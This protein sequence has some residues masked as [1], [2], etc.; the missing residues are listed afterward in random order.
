MYRAGWLWALFPYVEPDRQLNSAEETVSK[1]EDER[2]G[3]SR[4]EVWSLFDPRN[5]Q[6]LLIGIWYAVWFGMAILGVFWLREALSSRVWLMPILL[7]LTLTAIH[8]IYWS[9]MRMRAPMMPVVYMIA[10]WP[11]MRCARRRACNS[12]VTCL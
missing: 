3:E 4:T 12:L 8:M 6:Q 2:L 1:S 7:C 9:N 10:C 5:L 11:L